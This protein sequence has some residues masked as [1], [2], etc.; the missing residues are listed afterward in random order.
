VSA[1][2]LARPSAAVRISRLIT[3]VLIFVLLGPPIGGVIWLVLTAAGMGHPNT[4]VELFDGP[5]FVLFAAIFSYPFGAAPAA[6]AGLAIG[7][8]QAFFGRT[9]WPMALAIGLID[10]TVLLEGLDGVYPSARALN[11][12]PFP[13]YSAI[14]ILTCLV[15]TM[16]CWGLVRGPFFTPPSVAG[17]AP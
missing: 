3:I 15:P 14:L 8:K 17:A 1:A 11:V 5:V 2:L 7:I 16:L 10:G 4:Q 12:L 13:E 9:T 6:L